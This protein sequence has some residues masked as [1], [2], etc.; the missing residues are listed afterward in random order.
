M[1]CIHC[2][3]VINE[4]RLGRL[5]RDKGCRKRTLTRRRWNESARHL[6]ARE[7]EA[8]AGKRAPKSRWCTD[9]G[10]SIRGSRRGGHLIRRGGRKCWLWDASHHP[11]QGLRPWEAAGAT[12]GTSPGRAAYCGSGLKG[13]G[14]T[15]G[16]RGRGPPL[17]L[18]IVPDA[19]LN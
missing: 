18:H 15:V 10:P 17:G 11:H 3:K 19:S 2:Q 12:G 13:T 9:R 8:C 7:I 14:A 6:Q 1:H 4:Q 16:G 5:H